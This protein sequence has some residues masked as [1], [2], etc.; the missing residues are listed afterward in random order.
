MEAET[1]ALRITAVKLEGGKTHRHIT[2]LTWKTKSKTGYMTL[3]RIVGW[4]D[5]GK[6]AYVEDEFGDRAYLRTRRSSK[7]GLRYVQTCA[8]GVWQDNLLALPRF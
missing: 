8:D 6:E 7:T 4:L 1:V 2:R 5:E 3:S